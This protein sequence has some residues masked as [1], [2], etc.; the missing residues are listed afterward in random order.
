M[1]TSGTVP[2]ESLNYL[3]EEKSSR[4]GN[5]DTLRWSFRTPA[6]GG[7]FFLQGFNWASTWCVQQ[8]MFSRWQ[9]RRHWLIR[10]SKNI[11]PI[12]SRS[13]SHLQKW[14]SRPTWAIWTASLQISSEKNFEPA[15]SNW[16]GNSNWVKMLKTKATAAFWTSLSSQADDL[17]K[18]NSPESVGIKFRNGSR[19]SPSSAKRNS[20]SLQRRRAWSGWALVQE[21]SGD[22]VVEIER[23][24]C[25]KRYNH[26]LPS[27]LN[28]KAELHTWPKS[29]N[30]LKDSAHSYTIAV[31]FWTSK[32][33]DYY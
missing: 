31:V 24:V 23:H 28:K 19:S 26:V 3:R 32:A 17:T 4:G 7:G 27:L 15:A 21:L 2:V 30:R 33:D 1:S 29:I 20:W 6:L 22:W 25:C 13:A 11:A 14:C 5:K 16:A 12:A 10:C 18:R 9:R 8:W